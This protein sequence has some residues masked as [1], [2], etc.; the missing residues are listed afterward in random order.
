[1]PSRTGGEPEWLTPTKEVNGDWAL[2]VFV[3]GNPLVGDGPDIL[4]ETGGNQ[5]NG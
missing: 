5:E 1:V 2:L 4:Y 3:R